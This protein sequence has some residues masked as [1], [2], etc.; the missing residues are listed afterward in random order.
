[1]RTH[2][3]RGLSLL[4]LCVAVGLTQACSKKAARG[5]EAVAVVSDIDIGRTLKADGT[6]DDHTTTFRP[7]DVVHVTVGTRGEGSGTLRARWVYG[8][9][10]EI[11]TETREIG[12]DKA[13]RAEFRLSNP[14]GLAKG[15]YRVD[16]TL[17]DVEQGNKKFS[18][19]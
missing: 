17:N 13:R 6:I 1:M 16:I 7:S 19:D 5:S 12:P 14:K 18:V 2:M 8:D 4:S 11:A 9:N 15:D 10:Q 3:I